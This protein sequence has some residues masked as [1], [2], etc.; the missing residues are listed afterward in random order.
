MK[1]GCVRADCIACT[2]GSIRSGTA[3]YLG[4]AR[5]MG[6][7]LVCRAGRCSQP[8]FGGGA[9]WNCAVEAPAIE[10]TR[11]EKSRSRG[12]IHRHFAVLPSDEVTRAT[13]IPSRPSLGPFRPRRHLPGR[14]GRA[15]A[16]GV[17]IPATPRP[18]LAAGPARPPS[19]TPRLRR[20]AVPL[21]RAELP[22]AAPAAGSRLSSFRSC[23]A[24]VCPVLGS[25][26][27]F[28][29]EGGRFQVDCLWPTVGRSSNSMGSP[30]MA[31]GSPSGRTGLGTEAASGRVR[32][33]PD[34]A[35]AA[36]RRTRGDRGRSA[37]AGRGG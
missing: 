30:G 10:V 26:S 4:R 13:E 17:G 12:S 15:R 5:W 2:A 24:T 3:S 19:G 34:R 33:D 6:A 22:A 16:A 20:R 29:W 31:P 37:G 9:L 8:S 32:S 14:H 27:G 7:V 28:R 35:R 11:R 18:A 25:M 23:G 21:A 36:G 1:C